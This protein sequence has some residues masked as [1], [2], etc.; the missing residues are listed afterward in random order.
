ML[1]LQNGLSAYE[2]LELQILLG[3]SFLID[4]SLGQCNSIECMSGSRFVTRIA[5][6]AKPNTN[7]VASRYSFSSFG[8]TTTTIR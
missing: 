8:P 7:N 6:G 4:E 1:T 2:G 5:K 3:I